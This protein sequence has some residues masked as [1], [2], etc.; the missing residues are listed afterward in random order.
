MKKDIKNIKKIKKM[1]TAAGLATV[2][3]TTPM[4]VQASIPETKVEHN[5]E[6]EKD[7]IARTTADW[8]KLK[9]A[10][11]IYDCNPDVYGYQLLLEIEEYI[12]NNYNIYFD[13]QLSN[14]F[15]VDDVI[16]F[17]N[18]TNPNFSINTLIEEYKALDKTDDVAVRAFLEKYG[19]YLA[20]L[21]AHNY[22][23]IIEQTGAYRNE[24]AWYMLQAHINSDWASIVG[25]E[26]DPEAYRFTWEEYKN[27]KLSAD[28]STLELN[29]ENKKVTT[30]LTIANEAGEVVGDGY[31]YLVEGYNATLKEATL[32]G[33]YFH[34]T[35]TKEE[36]PEFLGHVSF[37]TNGTT[38]KENGEVAQVYSIVH[39][40]DINELLR[41]NVYRLTTMSP[42]TIV[43]AD[44]AYAKGID[45]TALGI[46]Y[47][48]TDFQYTYDEAT[49]TY[50]I[51]DAATIE[52]PSIEYLEV[53]EEN[54]ELAF[55]K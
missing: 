44:A 45:V 14:N 15:I 37:K 3:A 12:E 46:G 35:L 33:E 47:Y 17:R 30:N 26:V 6:D 28:M 7:V 16:A 34:G 24:I 10:Y 42:A 53:L 32:L 19:S 51:N 9:G 4:A 54:P 2:M 49:K 48:F 43:D 1:L 13:D 8:E 41:G 39:N 23:L 29:F 18:N 38:V 31:S 25:P 52:V 20:D 50:I 55:H 21:H 36:E 22:L 5:V 40:D 27:G 11:A